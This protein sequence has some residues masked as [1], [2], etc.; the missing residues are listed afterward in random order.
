M[1]CGG[2][3]TKEALSPFLFIEHEFSDYMSSVM[4]LYEAYNLV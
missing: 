2:S 1:L 4:S 3:S